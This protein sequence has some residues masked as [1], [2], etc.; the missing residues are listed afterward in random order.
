MSRLR[1]GLLLG[2]FLGGATLAA[3]ILAAHPHAEDA[4]LALL[5]IPIYSLAGALLGAVAAL[6]AP[7]LSGRQA[8]E[9]GPGI[10]L[11]GT[12]SALAVI[13]GTFL[14]G[15]LIDNSMPPLAPAILGL[16]IAVGVHLLGVAAASAASAWRVE[17]FVSAFSSAAGLC[18]LVVL[19]LLAAL[20]LPG[21][22]R[23]EPADGASGEM[24][25]PLNVVLVILDG[26]RADHLGCLGSFRAASPRFDA[27]AEESVLFDRAFAASPD[28]LDSCS[29][30]LGWPE[31]SL[32]A[33]LGASGWQ[34]WAITAN[35]RSW[36]SV[37]AEADG[38][39]Q[40]F[41]RREDALA[42]AWHRRLL[43]ARWT[44]LVRARYADVSKLRPADQVVDRALELAAAREPA[45]SFFMVAHLSDTVPPYDPPAELRDHFRPDGLSSED[46][47][48][49]VR[50]QD[51]LRL[52]MI[53]LGLLTA[54]DAE[55]QA[56]AALYDAEILSQDAALGR[57]IDGLLNLGLLEDT[58]LIVASDHGTR[59]GEEGGRLGNAGS[60]HDSVLR[61]PLLMRMPR[62]LPA[63][64]RAHGLVSLEDVAPA[65]RAVQSGS[66]EAVLLQAALG[67]SPRRA[68]TALLHEAGEPLRLVRGEHEKILLDS[69]G[70]VLAAGDLLADPD[71]AFLLARP[72]LDPETAARWRARAQELS[73]ESAVGSGA[74]GNGEGLRGD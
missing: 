74:G 70:Q 12:I 55:A 49:E 14:P 60:A 27:L 6:L 23:S 54:S 47:L 19:S 40:D 63:G 36:G 32:A 7:I 43:L 67:E 51:S 33:A 58:L 44:E 41:V 64:T 28:H 15:M 57:L 3:E 8:R 45:Q 69:R 2:A 13:I 4:R 31:N 1:H 66:L 65:V 48:R 59:F 37:G 35:P 39:L 5:W 11:L 25:P 22:A 61:V 17:S 50:D 10:L 24:K 16:G 56:F 71:E 34:T 38:P 20:V 62:L 68:V 21:P 52:S 26:V 53:E 46:L 42:G 30:L 9:R 73:T 72:A 29:R 18:L